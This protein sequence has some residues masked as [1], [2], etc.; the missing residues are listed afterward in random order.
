MYSSLMRRDSQ[1]L[2]WLSYAIQ[3]EQQEMEK[4]QLATTIL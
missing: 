3:S 1:G 4:K 2:D